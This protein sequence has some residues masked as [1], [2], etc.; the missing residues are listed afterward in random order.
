MGVVACGKLSLRHLGQK[1]RPRRPAGFARRRPGRLRT[2]AGRKVCP[3]G[4]R[5][6]PRAL[7]VR[8]PLGG[9]NAA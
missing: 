7:A 4:C 8:F 6:P 1:S 9:R 5:S 3:S 2:S